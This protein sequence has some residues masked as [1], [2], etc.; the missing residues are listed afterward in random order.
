MTSHK[1]DINWAGLY[2]H[3]GD[4]LVLGPFQGKPACMR[5]PFPKNLLTIIEKS[6]FEKCSILFKFKAGDPPQAD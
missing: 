5:I 6:F 2:I 1:P 4:E 3:R